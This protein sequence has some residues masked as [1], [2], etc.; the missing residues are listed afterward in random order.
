M[1]IAALL[2]SFTPLQVLGACFALAWL[3]GLAQ[4]LRSGRKLRVRN[5]VSATLYS[6][7]SGL[8]AGLVGF[9]Y[10]GGEEAN[11]YL[12]VGAS[13]LV[14]LGSVTILDILTNGLTP[15]GISISIRR[16]EGHDNE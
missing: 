2:G 11:T 16:L 12:L 3:G 15:K 10:L 5:L 13:G 6:G 9:T 1:R 8:I 7:L 14:G 4:L